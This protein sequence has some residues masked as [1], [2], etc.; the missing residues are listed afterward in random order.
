MFLRARIECQAL[1]LKFQWQVKQFDVAFELRRSTCYSTS[2]CCRMLF[3]FVLVGLLNHLLRLHLTK[4]GAQ[5]QIASRQARGFPFHVR[6]GAR[7]VS[8]WFII[9]WVY[10]VDFKT[11]QDYLF[12]CE[13]GFLRTEFMSGQWSSPGTDCA[14]GGGSSWG[15]LTCMSLSPE[16][17]QWCPTWHFEDLWSV[18][19]GLTWTQ[20]TSFCL[21]EA[22]VA[23]APVTL[24]QV[25][26]GLKQNRTIHFNL[27]LSVFLSDISFGLFDLPWPLKP[28]VCL[29]L[30]R[31]SSLIF[32]Q[33]QWCLR[34]RWRSVSILWHLGLTKTVRFWQALANWLPQG[35]SGL[36][37]IG[38]A[39]ANTLGHAAVHS[40]ATSAACDAGPGMASRWFGLHLSSL[41]MVLIMSKS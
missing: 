27:Q 26:V 14:M 16:M 1:V 38:H 7:H 19:S 12:S 41:L 18:C 13:D 40:P 39:G 33:V 11:F 32:Q 29:S 4:A 31:S 28:E 36:L 22:Q 25:P 17:F 23:G 37:S 30:I 20:P 24:V 34:I 21:T 2:F 35:G 5:A 8:S 3:V 6:Y 15:C 10:W 9:Y